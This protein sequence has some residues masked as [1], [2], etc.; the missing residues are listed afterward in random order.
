VFSLDNFDYSDIAGAFIGREADNKDTIKIILIAK[1][2]RQ[3]L[4]KFDPDQLKDR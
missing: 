4:R 3:L 1:I 2:T